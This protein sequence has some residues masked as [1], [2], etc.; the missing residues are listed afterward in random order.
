MASLPEDWEYSVSGLAKKAGCG[1]DKLRRILGEL[2]KVGYLAREQSHGSNGKFGGNIYIIQ[3]DAPP[4]SG[5][6]DNGPNPVNGKHRHRVSRHKR[7][8]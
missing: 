4:L 6:P 1:K 3:D 8:I 2:E 7:R 5:N